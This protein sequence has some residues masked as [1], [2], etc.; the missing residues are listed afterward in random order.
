MAVQPIPEGFHTVT[1]YLFV[2]EVPRLME[3]VFAAF[4]AEVTSRKARSDGS[5]MHAETRIGDSML[6]M[7]ES[8]VNSGPCRP[9][10]ISM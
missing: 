5:I 4:D 9:R 2:A 7:G 1:P 8:A 3:F 10:S 6:M